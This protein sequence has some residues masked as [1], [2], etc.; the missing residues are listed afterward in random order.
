MQSLDQGGGMDL[1][2][3]NAAFDTMITQGKAQLAQAGERVSSQTSADMRY[4]EQV[5]EI[6]VPLEGVDTGNADAVAW[7]KPSIG[8]T[9]RCSHMRCAGR[10]SFSS[11]PAPRSLARSRRSAAARRRGEPEAR[12]LAAESSSAMPGPR[13]RSMYAVEL[14]PSG[15]S[16]HVSPQRPQLRPRRPHSSTPR[17]SVVDSGGC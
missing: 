3:L 9:R 11:T 1:G 4:D 8:A 13:S 17:G 16:P 15:F 7:P 10:T 2:A 6:T 14:W 5:F 12:R